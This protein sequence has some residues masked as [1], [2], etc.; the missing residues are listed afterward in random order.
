V[1]KFVAKNIAVDNSDLFELDG[2]K[3]LSSSAG[4]TVGIQSKYK[5]GILTVKVKEDGA[6]KYKISKIETSPKDANKLF[7]GD[8]WEPNLFKGADTVKGSSQSDALYGYKGGDEIHGNAGD[9]AIY[10]G[11]GADS[12]YGGDGG[13]TI[14]GD[15]GDDQLFGG[16]GFNFL[17]G[18]EGRDTF[19]FDSDLVIGNGS[20]IT[21]FISGSDRI[22]LDRDIFT[23]IGSTGKLAAAK[24]ILAD[25]YAGQD[26]VVIYDLASG[27]LG[28]TKVGGSTENAM[29]FGAVTA[30]LALSNKDFLIV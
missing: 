28:Y 23:G 17:T 25:D 13:D 6:L 18:G 12:L 19:R 8:N 3:P 21:D 15:A 14:F 9:D 26:H 2:Y 20:R 11:K 10:G 27:T 1:V 24:L 29:E 30:G 4:A 22:E 16:P 5:N 7:K